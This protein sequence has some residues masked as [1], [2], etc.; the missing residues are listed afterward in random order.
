MVEY[1]WEAFTTVFGFEVL[2]LVVLVPWEV[3][4]PNCLCIN[5]FLPSTHTVV[6]TQLWVGCTKNQVRVW[7]CLKTSFISR[8][9]QFIFTSVEVP[10]FRAQS[11]EQHKHRHGC[12][13]A[14]ISLRRHCHESTGRY[15]ILINCQKVFPRKPNLPRHGQ[16]PCCKIHTKYEKIQGRFC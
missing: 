7:T 9:P 10:C 15:H 6:A 2:F 16:D 4:A 11:H 3:P 1:C 5:L 14:G 12:R 8:L 13:S